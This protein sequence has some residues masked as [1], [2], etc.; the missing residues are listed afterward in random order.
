MTMDRSLWPAWRIRK[1]RIAGF[2]LGMVSLLAIKVR[3]KPQAASLLPT[4]SCR[5]GEDLWHDASLVLLR[6]SLDAPDDDCTTRR[7]AE[8]LQIVPSHW[9]PCP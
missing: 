2:A 8:A 4:H 7:F 3:V 1:R 6:R 5:R 9:F